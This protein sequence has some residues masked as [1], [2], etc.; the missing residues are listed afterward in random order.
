[1]H[2]DPPTCHGPLG[3]RRERQ[4][5]EP[6]L[7]EAA[8]GR[9]GRARRRGGLAAR[10][11]YWRRAHP[12][13]RPLG[14]V[15]T[16]GLAWRVLR[17]AAAGPRRALFLL[18]LLALHGRPGAA[19]TAPAGGVH[20]AYGL[21]GVA[22]RLSFFRELLHLLDGNCRQKGDIKDVC[23]RFHVACRITGRKWAG[24]AENNQKKCLF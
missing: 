21:A 16:L 23:T 11:E 13:A 20:R 7:R 5:G 6:P 18:L 4:V 10:L 14:R 22:L 8:E 9:G 3:R 24:F 19:I 15:I 2:T 12:A 1:M 17:A